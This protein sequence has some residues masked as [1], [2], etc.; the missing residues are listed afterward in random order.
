[1]RRVD[2]PGSLKEVTIHVGIDAHFTVSRV[3]VKTTK[4]GP[5]LY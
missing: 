5:V 4:P 2:A 3:E 1:M